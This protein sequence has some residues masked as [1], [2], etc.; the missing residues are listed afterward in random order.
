MRFTLVMVRLTFY[1]LLRIYYVTRDLTSRACLFLVSSSLT[2]LRCEFYF[3]IFYLLTLIHTL[4]IIL[5]IIYNIHL[6]LQS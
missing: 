4:V 5:G 3:Y 6:L 2:K 1:Y